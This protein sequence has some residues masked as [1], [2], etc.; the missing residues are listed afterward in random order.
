MKFIRGLDAPVSRS[1]R[2][3]SA[4]QAACFPS[5]RAS[6]EDSGLDITA[7][8]LK[9]STDSCVWT[10]ASCA[11]HA[12]GAGT[13]GAVLNL[14]TEGVLYILTGGG[15]RVSSSGLL[16]KIC[17]R[18]LSRGAREVHQRNNRIL[19]M[20]IL[21]IGREQ[22]IAKSSNHLLCSIKLFSFSYAEGDAGGNQL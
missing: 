11:A 18:R 13:H 21:R 3:R 20:F 22:H 15:G 7:L 14:Q 9:Y 16:T 1:T 19:H 4:A 10:F 5:L 17:P 6:A 12:R 2:L 8:N